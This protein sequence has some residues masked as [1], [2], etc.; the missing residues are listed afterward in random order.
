MASLRE[1]RKRMREAFAEL[2]EAIKDF[3]VVLLK[4]CLTSKVFWLW[5]LIGMF[6]LKECP[7]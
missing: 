2:E 7:G 3:R 6:L 5:C 4:T 1:E